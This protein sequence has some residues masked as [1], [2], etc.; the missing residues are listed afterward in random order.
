MTL[1][2]KVFKFKNG[3]Y[4]LIEEV[5]FIASSPNRDKDYTPNQKK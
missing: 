5:L 3:F 1:S 2:Q 4:L